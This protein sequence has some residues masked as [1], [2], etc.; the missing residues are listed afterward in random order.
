[1]KRI[2][3][4]AIPAVALGTLIVWRLS[5]NRQDKAMQQQA[6]N[7]RKNSAPNVSV[8]PAVIRDIVHT[9]EAVGNVE[10]PFNVK[11][12]AKV[13]GRLDYQPLREGDHV[14]QGQVVARIDPSEVEATVRQQ[15]A[16]VAEAQYRL[17]QAELTT[18]P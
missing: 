15:Q 16:A 1:M 8:A 4:F 17:T 3:I 10:A 7:A 12:A 11:I 13:T 6:A 2:L 18:N 14:T 9:F 5:A